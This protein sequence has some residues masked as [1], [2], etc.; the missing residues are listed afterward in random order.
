MNTVHIF[1]GAFSEAAQRFLRI[2]QN[3]CD[4]VF[5]DMHARS[6][7]ANERYRGCLARVANWDQS[8]IA[9]ELTRLTAAFPDVEAMFR[10][11]FVTYVKAMRSSKTTRLLV[12]T[13]KIGQVLHRVMHH[14]SEI[15]RWSPPLL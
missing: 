10:T 1:T 12:N 11:V 15:R 6:A 4:H 13:P 8:V 7:H 2:V 5:T 9:E 14:F 3:S